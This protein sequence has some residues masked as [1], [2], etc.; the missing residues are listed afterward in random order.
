[1][2]T[3]STCSAL[4]RS[5]DCGIALVLIE[6]FGTVAERPSLSVH[7]NRWVHGAAAGT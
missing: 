1:M 3:N 4:G 6:A 2:M 7:L 5:P